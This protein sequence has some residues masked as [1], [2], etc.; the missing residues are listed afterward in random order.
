MAS[1]ADGRLAIA[2]TLFE[3]GFKSDQIE[4]A[5]DCCSTL[6][7]ALRWLTPKRGKDAPASGSRAVSKGSC[8]Q[9]KR[10]MEE[11]S[12]SPRSAKAVNIAA[13][14]AASPRPVK[15]LLAY[16]TAKAS[17]GRNRAGGF[18]TGSVMS[19][20]SPGSG[21]SGQSHRRVESNA[22]SS[23]RKHGQIQ[24]SSAPR[25]MAIEPQKDANRWWQSAAARW[26]SISDKLKEQARTGVVQQMREPQSQSSSRRSQSPSTMARFDSPPQG[27]KRARTEAGVTSEAPA[28]KRPPATP[29][30][31]DSQTQQAE[32]SIGQ[33]AQSMSPARKPARVAD[34]SLLTSPSAL[35]INT[36]TEA[37]SLCCHDIP[38]WRAVRLG[39][40][41]GW[42][43][44]QCVLRHTEAR[45]AAGSSSV[46]CPECS[47]ELAER[48]LRKMLPGEVM[49]RL[50]Q[51]SLEQAISTAS[52]LHACPTPNCPM[53]VAIEDGDDP[54][55]RCMLCKKESCI[56]CGVQP[57]HKGLTCEA[58]KKAQLRRGG[59]KRDDDASIRRWLQETGT[60]QCP[61]CRMGVSKQNLHKQ[62]TQYLECH[63]MF[64]RNCNTRFCFKCLT[65]LTETTKCGCTID[66]HGFINPHTG[67]R[68][69]HIRS[70]GGKKGAKKARA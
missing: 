7:E 33:D 31:A 64:C 38:A 6:E 15:A 29:S 67:R 50:L 57:F 65:V 69:N 27:H 45:L 40:S 62:K 34:P 2:V 58:F 19:Q 4:Q 12:T 56:A 21:M 1:V 9:S 46:T 47:A 20:G 63:K 5:L 10:G 52:D 39:C 49:E 17:S 35:R 11:A 23:P 14:V 32:E 43:C 54:R 13:R 61:T 36:Q 48:E 66:A 16:D 42:Y 28:A 30:S 8:K 24:A 68:I 41:H 55:F 26:V 53:R 18:A 37:C 59:R 70:D 51:R 22:Q 3:Q 25:E 44:A 60:V